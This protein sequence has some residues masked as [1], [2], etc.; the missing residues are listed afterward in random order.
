MLKVRLVRS[1]GGGLDRPAHWGAAGWLGEIEDISSRA[2]GRD[3]FVFA[4]RFVR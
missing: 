4:A 2:G 3:T 1:R